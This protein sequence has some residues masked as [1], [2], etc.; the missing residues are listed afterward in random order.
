[1]TAYDW[2]ASVAFMPIGYAI[3]GPLADAVGVTEVLVTFAVLHVVLGLAV[4]SLP[5]VRRIES[6]AATADRMASAPVA[7]ASD[8]AAE[9]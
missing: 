5:V 7:A 9:P 6:G 1:V 3:V 8:P 2:L 4:L